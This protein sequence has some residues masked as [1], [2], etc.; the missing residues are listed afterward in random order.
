MSH[1]NG[2]LVEMQAKLMSRNKISRPFELAI[3]S[4][5]L[6]DAL[7]TVGDYVKIYFLSLSTFPIVCATVGALFLSSDV[8]GYFRAYFIFALNIFILPNYCLVNLNFSFPQ[9][10][11]DLIDLVYLVKRPHLNI[12]RVDHAA[13]RRYN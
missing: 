10:N 5:I 9:S 11:H 12:I 4:I 13:K 3:E 6:T 1:R 7:L 2:K 8:F